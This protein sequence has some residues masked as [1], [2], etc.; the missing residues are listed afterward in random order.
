MNQFS[1][2]T[3]AP[4]HP[5]FV[6]LMYEDSR[7]SRSWL[8][9]LRNFSKQELWKLSLKMSQC[10]HFQQNVNW[11]WIEVNLICRTLNLNFYVNIFCMKFWVFAIFTKQP[12]CMKERFAGWRNCDNGNWRAFC[13][14][15]V[16]F[17]GAYWS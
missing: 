9:N 10:Y 14:I 2:S 1:T 4:W 8:M 17:K 6:F 3:V 12:F 13:Q 16:H 15:G 11:Q 7:A 5:E